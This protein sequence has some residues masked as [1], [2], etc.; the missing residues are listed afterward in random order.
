MQKVLIMTTH[1]NSLRSKAVGWTHQDA[2]LVKPGPIG[3][4]PAPTPYAAHPTP[5]H[6]LAD[7][8]RLLAPPKPYET[9]TFVGT[10]QTEWEWWFVK[11]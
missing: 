2:D 10:L 9:T 7:G 4:T 11:D 3:N 1:S 8:W 6:A 5:M